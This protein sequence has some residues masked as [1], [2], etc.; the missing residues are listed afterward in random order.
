MTVAVVLWLIAA[1]VPGAALIRLAWPGAGLLRTV[2]AAPPVSF[3]FAYVL[4]LAASRLSVWPEVLVVVGAAAAVLAT[5]VVDAFRWRARRAARRTTGL[6]AQAWPGLRAYFGTRPAGRMVSWALLAGGVVL[7]ALLWR[8]FQSSLLVP[9]SWD[10]MHHGFF[11]KQISRFH[12]MDS[13]VVLASDTTVHD[14][15]GTFYP[16]AF[17]L[18]A[19]TLHTVT[20]GVISTIMLASTVALAGILLPIG[21]YALAAELDPDRPLVAGFSAITP[22]LPILL[23]LVEGTGRLTGILGVA[24]VPGLVVLLVAQRGPV[25]WSTLPLA[26]LGLVGIIGMHVSEA[27]LAV[28]TAVVCVAVWPGRLSDLP[29]LW[30]WGAWLAAAGAAGIVGLLVLEPNL[31]RLASERSG[32]IVHPVYR[33][34]GEVL[35]ATMDATGQAWVLPVVGCLVTLLPRWRRFRGA[36]VT[37]VLF[38]LFFFGVTL[39][40]RTLMPTLA[41]PWY[42]NPG[43]ISWD[44]TVAAAV[45]TAVGLAAIASLVAR[46]A[47]VLARFVAGTDRPGERPVLARRIERWTPPLVA[48]FAGVLLVVAFAL[49]PVARQG[50]VV[51]DAAGPVDRD[52]IAAF[53]YLA[54]HVRP[55]EKVLDDLRTDGAMW[56]YVD[57]DVSPLFGSSPLYGEAPR[58]W[59]EKLWLSRHLVKISTDPCVRTMLDKYEIRYVYVGDAHIYDGWHDFP[60]H[61]MNNRPE[62]SEVFHQGNAHVFV[63]NPGET[64]G[65]C[66]RDVAAAVYWG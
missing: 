22:V 17:N 31:I 15:G 45:P 63:I 61:W 2:A 34:F 54:A 3:G 14:G 56:M 53:H 50:R 46:G 5:A 16:L 48:A 32:A 28:L 66:E 60:S 51:S 35:A 7:G 29:G 25:R 10:A 30:R 12:T 44:L 38:A 1:V 24:L 37:L 55:D 6:P 41:I 65:V 23:Y 27:P 39:G 40:L 19:A 21:S 43:R 62:F 59:K 26:I 8:T 36:A 4:G 20:G 11:I 64:P 57:H 47:T 49:P 33:P 52:S 9:A 58:S 42:G 18:V 13:S